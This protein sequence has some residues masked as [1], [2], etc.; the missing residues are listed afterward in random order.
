[1]I[2]TIGYGRRDLNQLISE[3]KRQADFVVD[4]RSKPDASRFN[5]QV[6][7]SSFRK[8][9]LQYLWMAALGGFPVKGC[10]DRQGYI[11]YLAMMQQPGYQEAIRQLEHI[12]GSVML[13]CC[14]GDPAKCHRTKLIGETL[15]RKGT[16]IHHIEASGQL[17]EHASVM[18]RIPKGQQTRSCR[19][20]AAPKPQKYHF[21]FE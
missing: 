9:G 4:V 14:E 11:D 2:M 5:R 12:K 6:L 8:N 15:F 20:Y 3:I 7:G 13:M 18:A 16:T 19:C 10:K 17:S 21:V 1:M